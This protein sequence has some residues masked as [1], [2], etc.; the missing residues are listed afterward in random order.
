MLP[1][2]SLNGIKDAAAKTAIDTLH[3]ALLEISS[4]LGVGLGGP[5]TAPANIQSVTA[6]GNNGWIDVTI[7][8]ATTAQSGLVT[9]VNYFVV[10]DTGTLNLKSSPTVALGPGRHYRFY[11]G[12]AAYNI[13]AYSSFNDSETSAL[14]TAAGS[15]IN[16]GGS[17][18]PPALPAPPQGGST[19]IGLGGGYG[20]GNARS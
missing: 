3:R 4:K 1:L 13:G 17:V 6:A 16:G 5:L 12:N 18:T 7:N 2:P 19:G 8:D 9:Q 15:P 14:V 20:R 10:Y 11:A